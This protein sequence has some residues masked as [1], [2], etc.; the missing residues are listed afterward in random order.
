MFI[1][2]KMDAESNETTPAIA[3]LRFHKDSEMFTKKQHQKGLLL[4]T[5]RR[6]RKETRTDMESATVKM[7]VE[8]NETTPMIPCLLCHEDFDI[9]IT[10]ISRKT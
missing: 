10:H 8:H 7:D 6:V 4:N 2:I 1:Y 3:F 5:N 9:H